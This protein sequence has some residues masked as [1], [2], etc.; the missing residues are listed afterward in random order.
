MG[1]QLL[2]SSV[3]SSN[4]KLKRIASV[5]LLLFVTCLAVTDANPQTAFVMTPCQVGQRAP[6]IGF[7]TW[8]A[9]ARVNVYIVSTDFKAEEMSRLLNVLQNWNS[10]SELTGSGV[11]LEYHGNTDRQLSCENCLTI[12]RGTVFDKSKKHLT[13]LT[14]F[15]ARHDQVISYAVIAV[16]PVLTNPK[17]I[18]DAL[19]HEL[20]HNFGLLDCFTCKKKSTVMNQFKA[21]NVANDMAAP[22]PCDIAQVKAAYQELKVRVRPSPPDRSLIDEGEEPVDDD[23]PIIIPKP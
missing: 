4:M 16:D 5:I 9:N 12:M 15:S 22:S 13:S 2:S 11:K 20:G 8:A 19:A 21:T 7:W 18:A 10:V 14:A 6:A 1:F 3:R 23:T 17:A